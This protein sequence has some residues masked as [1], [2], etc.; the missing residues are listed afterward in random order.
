M[1]G[2]GYYEYQRDECYALIDLKSYNNRYLDFQVN[3]P[4]HLSALE[5]RL[6]DYL[7]S[8]INRGRV[9]V[10]MKLIT[11]EQID[12]L[13]DTESARSITAILQQLIDEVGINDQVRLSHLLRMEGILKPQRKIDVD[14]Y[15]E[16]L[17]PHLERAFEE[18]EQSRITEGE[19]IERDIL[20]Q[21]NR[22]EEGV[23]IIDKNRDGLK[24]II[25]NGLRE[26]FFE[27]LGD[28]VD[29][30]RVYSEAAILLMKFDVN[31]EVA[32]LAAHV[33]EFRETLK[34]DGGIG[35]KLDFICQELNREINTIGSK[36]TQLEIHS[37]VISV[38][39]AIERIREQL[40]NVE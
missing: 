3:L 18:F 37:T 31:E 20:E 35:K 39:E 36:S 4:P 26:R 9:E 22:I 8:R 1:T 16:T 29:E 23:R 38:K 15:W 17:V 24:E 5:P 11:D 7:S 21:L 13:V 25:V 19:K 40:R 30:N 2:F 33:N 34:S 28:G 10:Y 32:R 14:A 12:L 27:L 6:R